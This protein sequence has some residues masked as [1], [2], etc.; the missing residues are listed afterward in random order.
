MDSPRS[1]LTFQKLSAGCLQRLGDGGGP[2]GDGRPIAEVADR[3]FDAFDDQL[4]GQTE[5]L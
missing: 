2:G 4:L 3:R 1:F 5:F